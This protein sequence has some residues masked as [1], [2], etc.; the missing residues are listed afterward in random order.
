MKNMAYVDIQKKFEEKCLEEAEEIARRIPE[1]K[2][3]S[4]EEVK[5]LYESF[6]HHLS[7]GWIIVSDGSIENFRN[8]FLKNEE[9]FGKRLQQ[10]IEMLESQIFS[11]QE[12]MY[13]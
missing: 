13:F 11:L 10:K 9:K 4:T 1:M 2:D 5:E 8:W 12:E 7:A 3:F 6:S